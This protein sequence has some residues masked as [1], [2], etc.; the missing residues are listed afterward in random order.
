MEKDKW[1]SAHSCSLWLNASTKREWM[2]VL[3]LLASFRNLGLLLWYR[4]FTSKILGGGFFSKV[5]SKEFFFLFGFIPNDQIMSQHVTIFFKCSIF[6]I[7]RVGG[8]AVREWNINLFIHL[9]M[10]SLVDSCMCS[11]QRWNHNLRALTNGVTQP[12]LSLH[13]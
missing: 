13:F 9:F 6:I 11:D 2:L 4:L 12:A 10:H 3:N 1:R 8:G 5:L 7:E